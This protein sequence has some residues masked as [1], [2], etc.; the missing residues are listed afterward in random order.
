MVV[1]CAVA[2]STIN[3]NH[4]PSSLVSIA[5]PSN[6]PVKLGFSL[7]LSGRACDRLVLWLGLL[8][9]ERATSCH[10]NRRSG[11]KESRA[12]INSRH[13]KAGP[14]RDAAASCSRHFARVWPDANRQMV[15]LQSLFTCS[16]YKTLNMYVP[17]CSDL[18]YSSHVRPW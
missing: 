13:K 14:T 11:T 7:P 16:N 6:R 18:S 10:W 15:W 8:R 12:H 17:T 4:E 2:E 1:A 3:S 5:T 9:A